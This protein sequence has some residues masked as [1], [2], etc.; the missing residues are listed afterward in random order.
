MFPRLIEIGDFGLPTY[1]VLAATGLL[2]GL[3]IAVRMARREG[4]DPDKVWNMGIWA[5]LAAIL[6]AKLLLLT[7]AWQFYAAHP[8]EIFTLTTLQAG[9]VWQGG[10]AGAIL[11]SAFY[12][13][14][15]RMPVLKTFDAFAPGIALGH[16]IGRLGCFAA[17]CCFGKETDLPWGVTFTDPLAYAYSRTPLGVPLHPTQLYEFVAELLFFG[18]LLWLARRKSFDGQMIGA[19]LFLY[20]FARYFFEFVRDDPDRGFVFGGVMTVTQ[21]IALLMVIGGGA[22]WMRWKKAEAAGAVR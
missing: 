14:R 17:G 8:R 18:V 11:F 2:T 16:A 19:Y 13:R 12:L 1:G 3:F 6:G 21:V 10:L 4:L 9:G 5:V 7:T 15:H 20:G 22:L